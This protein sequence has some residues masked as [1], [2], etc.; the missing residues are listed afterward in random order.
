M[1]ENRFKTFLMLTVVAGIGGAGLM[2]KGWSDVA[3]LEARVHNLKK[4][5]RDEK[6]IRG[7]LDAAEAKVK[8]CSM[9]LKH[10][11]L[12]VPDMAY[13]PTLLTELESVGNKCGIEVT[14]V[15][16]VISKKPIAPKPVDGTERK[17][18]YEE[19]EIEV[20]GKGNYE[21]VE[22]FIAALQTFP[23]IVAVRMITMTPKVEAQAKG[24]DT[25]DVQINLKAFVFPLKRGEKVEAAGVPTS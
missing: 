10:L 25:L 22:R 16:P 8:Q 17:K 18:A 20:K 11:E 13:V 5:A 1:A 2:Y 9:E 14:G 3:D 12:G 24:M 4:D 15:R 7:D 21:S 19:Q 23:K 6:Q